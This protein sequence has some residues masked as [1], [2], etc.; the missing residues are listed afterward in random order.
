MAAGLSIIFG[1]LKLMN[2]AQGEFYMLGAYVTFFLFSWFHVEASLS[3]LAAVVV[4]FGLAYLIEH[5]ILRYLRVTSGKEWIRNSFVVTLGLS[6]ILQNLALLFWGA[7]FYGVTY[8]WPGTIVVMGFRT[9]LDRLI[10]VC[11]GFLSLLSMF[12]F[13]KLTYTGKAIR[14]TSQNDDA[15]RIVGIDVERIYAISFGLGCMIS[16]LAGGILMPLT[17]AFPTV[18]EGPL[19]KGFIVVTLGGLGSLRG[20][21]VGGIILGLLEALTIYFL[22]SG[23]QTVISLVVVMFI[24]LARPEG[25]FRE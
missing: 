20:S 7:N 14:A 9:S 8:L 1:V 3:V 16:A 25:I 4:V 15:A 6:I 24:L 22:N 12:A 13:I 21:V 17:S 2:F 19:L 18:G 10:T 23:W 11:I 5:F